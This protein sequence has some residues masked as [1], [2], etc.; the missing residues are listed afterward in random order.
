MAGEDKTR[1][2]FLKTATVALGGALG[3]VMALPVV[4]YVFYPMGRR[5]VSSSTDP[6]DVLAA[7]SLPEGGDPVRVEIRAAAMRDGWNVKRDVALGSAWVRQEEGGEVRAFSSV[8]PHLGCAVGYS[9]DEGTF[10]CPC[11]KSSFALDGEKLGGPSKRGLDPLP[12]SVEDGR[13][14]VTFIRYQTD[15][16]ERKPV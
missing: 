15:I 10:V 1:R 5:V 3:A 4:R 6:V 16:P 9:Q 8:C 11:H 14:K 12:V 7:S 2:G 13:V